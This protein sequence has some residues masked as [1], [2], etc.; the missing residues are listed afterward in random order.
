MA[1]Y[2]AMTE[3]GVGLLVEPWHDLVLFTMSNAEGGKVP[4]PLTPE[5]AITLGEALIAEG[6]QAKLALGEGL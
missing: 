6:L 4:L 5:E 3:A 2:E 1:A